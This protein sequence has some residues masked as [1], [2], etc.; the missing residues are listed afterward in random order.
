[1]IRYTTAGLA[2]DAIDVM[3]HLNWERAHVLGN[4]LGGMVAQELALLAP[5]RIATLSLVVTCSAGAGATEL[6]A[7]A[8][9]TKMAFESDVRKKLSH[10]NRFLFLQI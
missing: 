10:G 4:S 2:K 6:V 5:A 9:L 3:D 8:E 1:M 7:Y